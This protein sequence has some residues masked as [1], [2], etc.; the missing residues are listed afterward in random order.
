MSELDNEID[1]VIYSLISVT[2]EE[3]PIAWKNSTLV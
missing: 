2:G 3:I 1:P